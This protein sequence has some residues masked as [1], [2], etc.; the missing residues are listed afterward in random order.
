MQRSTSSGVNP[1]ACW[2]SCRAPM[3]DVAQFP[4]ASG[5]LHDGRACEATDLIGAYIGRLRR[6][7]AL[8]GHPAAGGDGPCAGIGIAARL[9]LR[10]AALVN[11]VLLHRLDFD[12]GSFSVSCRRMIHPRGSWSVMNMTIDQFET[13]CLQ[14]TVRTLRLQS[15]DILRDDGRLPANKNDLLLRWARPTWIGGDYTV[16]GVLL[17]GKNPGGGSSSNLDEP[18]PLDSLSPQPSAGY[19]KDRTSRRTATGV[20]F[21]CKS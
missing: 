11:A 19:G 5:S 12:D 6:R 20:M 15:T 13:A 8:R 4:A 7:D 3:V 10:D 17:L 16:G 1:T 14:S 21:S 2:H 18:H 9:P